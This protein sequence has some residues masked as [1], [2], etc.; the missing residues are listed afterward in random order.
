MP[1]PS[2]ALCSAK[3]MIRT[4][5]RPIS[6]VLAETPIARPSAKLCRPIAAAIVMPVRSA[7]GAG[8]ALAAE[9]LRLLDGH[10]V[11]RA[12]GDRRAA[13]DAA[14]PALDHRQPALPA[15]KPP[16]SSS[17]PERLA[18]APL[19]V[20]EALDRVLDDPER[21]LEDVH[22]QEREH[23]DREHREA[24]TRRGREHLQPPERQAQV[25]REPASAPARQSRRSSS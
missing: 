5:A 19:A 25:D 20:L 10:R 7:R 4:V 24:D 1:K 22:E 16:P 11:G 9:G 18:E 6:P 14:H 12:T 3:P 15:A 21:V 23:A 2:V 8:R 17:A 13:V